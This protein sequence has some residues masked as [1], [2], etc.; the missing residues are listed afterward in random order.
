MLKYKQYDEGRVVSFTRGTDMDVLL[1]AN[2]AKVVPLLIRGGSCWRM[3]FS[4]QQLLLFIYQCFVAVKKNKVGGECHI[5]SS[6][7]TLMP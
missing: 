6:R 1:V 7:G 2:S 5:G 3:W 4:Q